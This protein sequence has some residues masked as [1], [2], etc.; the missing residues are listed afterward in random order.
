MTCGE[1]SRR[2]SFFFVDWEFREG[3]RHP[4]MS[5]N[6]TLHRTENLRTSTNENKKKAGDL[7]LFSPVCDEGTSH[8]SQAK[9]L[10]SPLATSLGWEKESGVGCRVDCYHLYSKTYRYLSHTPLV[11]IGGVNDHITLHG[12]KSHSHHLNKN[13]SFAI[14]FLRVPLLTTPLPSPHF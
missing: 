2:I 5:A 3:Q 11:V 1:K 6:C 14:D 4:G 13:K 9:V 12:T 7:V 10:I 8:T